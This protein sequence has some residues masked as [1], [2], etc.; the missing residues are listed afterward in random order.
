[1]KIVL[2]WKPIII[3]LVIFY[4]SV[5]SSSNLNKFELIHLE[6]IDK[7]IHYILYFV[8]GLTFFASLKKNILISKQELVFLTL[9]LVI[10]YGVLM[11]VFQ[12]YFTIDRSADIMDVLAN[13]FGCV[14]GILVYPLVDKLKLTRY[15]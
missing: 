1:M 6:H 3:A 9:V 7:F 11:E 10:S 12:F 15:L 13:S 4:G 8:L 14:S 2:Y 5:T